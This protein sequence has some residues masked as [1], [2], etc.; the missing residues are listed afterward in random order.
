MNADALRIIDANLNRAREGLR[1]LEEHARFVLDDAELTR[2]T[3]ELRH[4]LRDVS[5]AF[6]M[7]AVAARDIQHDVGTSISTS[8]ER[9][10][11]DTSDVA[12]AAA[13]RVS[14]SLRCIEEYGKIMNSTAAAEA[15][16]IR[17]RLY[18]IEQDLLVSAPRRERLKAARLH[19][20]LTESLCNGPWLDVARQA[21]VGGADV[22]QLREKGL[23]DRDLLE[24]ARVLRSL[25]R[26]YGALLTVNDRPDIARLA[27]ADI[28]HVGQ[29]DLPVAD[30][31]RITGPGILIGKSTHSIEQ[32][33]AAMAERPDYIAV[34]PMFASQTKMNAEVQGPAL[35]QAVLSVADVPIVAIGGITKLHLPALACEKPIQIAVCQAVIGASDVRAATRALKAS[36]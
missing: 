29:D 3:K 22:L 36:C 7:D 5:K 21:L 28:V 31:R 18:A 14:E 8:T 6:G 32:A 23:S 34:G 19:V 17:Y 15:E 1:V 2:R 20:L 16:R 11:A 12:A 24:R 9:A 26:E 25:T 35:L 4:Q 10:R 13:K 27:M 33:K 30:A